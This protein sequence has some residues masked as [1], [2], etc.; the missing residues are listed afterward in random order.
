[1]AASRSRCVATAALP[2]A[3]ASLANTRTSRGGRDDVID[4]PFGHRKARADGDA[5][6]A[7]ERSARDDEADTQRLTLQRGVSEPDRQAYSAADEESFSRLKRLA[8]EAGFAP[9]RP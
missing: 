7:D 6:H 9:L 5:E 8:A 1:M 3:A 2:H 4:G